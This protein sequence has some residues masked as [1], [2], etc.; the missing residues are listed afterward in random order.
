MCNDMK[1]VLDEL[2]FRLIHSAEENGTAC[3]NHPFGFIVISEEY[4]TL[5][6][7]IIDSIKILSDSYEEKIL[8]ELF[9]T[10]LIN[11]IKE[12]NPPRLIGRI[13]M[14]KRDNP[15]WKRALKMLETWFPNLKTTIIRGFLILCFQGIEP[16]RLHL[17]NKIPAYN[18]FSCL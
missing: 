2:I 13:I 1:I 16:L 11:S 3:T 7:R 6:R 9:I 12:S 17:Q 10:L 15:L 18:I 5:W 8:R 14:N 4:G